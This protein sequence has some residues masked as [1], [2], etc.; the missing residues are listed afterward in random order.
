MQLQIAAAIWCIPMSSFTIE[1]V[2]PEHFVIVCCLRFRTQ[3]DHRW[4]IISLRRHTGQSP[5]H[6]PLASSV[7]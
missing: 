6:L 7:V 4:I 5:S 3:G 1:Q 2:L